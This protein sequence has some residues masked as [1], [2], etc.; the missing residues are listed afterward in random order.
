MKKRL[1]S[2]LLL[3]ASIL[4]ACGPKDPDPDPD[5]PSPPE[6]PTPTQ[7]KYLTFVDAGKIRIDIFDLDVVI[8]YGGTALQNGVNVLDISDDK[9]FTVNMNTD[10]EK[11]YNF[12]AIAEQASGDHYLTKV[13][14]GVEGGHLTDFFE[15][16]GNQFKTFN[17]GYYAISMGSTPN[18]T[19]GLNNA[20][21][22]AI[23]SFI[24]QH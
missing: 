7:P 24:P 21:D 17:R 11:E 6:P 18:W 3:S 19:K 8:S 5:P 23:Q 4:C 12:I 20:M 22:L 14:A 2:V 16:N 10:D 9:V 15:L 13:N 1:F